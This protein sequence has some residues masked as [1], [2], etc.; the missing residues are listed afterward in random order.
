MFNGSD[1][2]LIYLLREKNQTAIDILY[3]RYS[4]H[5][6]WILNKI[7]GCDGSF[8]DIEDLFQI[9]WIKF[10]EV[11]EKYDESYGKFYSFMQLSIKRNIFDYMKFEKNKK[12]DYSL[13][14]YID[15]ESETL[16][17]DIIS[18]NGVNYSIKD[19]LLGKEITEKIHRNL[20]KEENEILNDK[21]AGYSYKEM[22]KKH[23][24]SVKTIDNKIS[25]IKRKIRNIID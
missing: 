24:K 12:I 25:K 11:I 3:Q 19:E 2:E 13:D 20:S 22:S 8:F 18:E 4:T 23:N 17:I 9:S 21:I 5:I 15:K 14:A 6:Y 10:I 1:E 7:Y 16:Y